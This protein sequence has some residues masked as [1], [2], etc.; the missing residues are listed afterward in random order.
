MIAVEGKN[1]MKRCF[2]R[3]MQRIGRHFIFELNKRVL[4]L[5]NNYRKE[6]YT[7][8]RRTVLKEKECFTVHS[9]LIFMVSTFELRQK[10]V[11][12]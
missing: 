8:T 4:H 3:R 2:Y 9:S 6:C 10:M 12:E 7:A 5:K 11:E 1:K